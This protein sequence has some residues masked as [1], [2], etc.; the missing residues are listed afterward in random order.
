MADPDPLQYKKRDPDPHKIAATLISKHNLLQFVWGQ[1]HVQFSLPQ[2]TLDRNENNQLNQ[3]GVGRVG[4]SSGIEAQLWLLWKYM[5]QHSDI[6]IKIID[7][8]IQ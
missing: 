8:S 6:V 7:K 4:E 1:I 5:I 2:A 3:N